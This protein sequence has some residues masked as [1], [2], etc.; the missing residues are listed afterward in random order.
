VHA[1]PEVLP[2]LLLIH[3]I[4]GPTLR[5]AQAQTALATLAA[6]PKVSLVASLDH[7]NSPLRAFA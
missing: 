2:L 1:D 3:N 7:L 5:N 4:D 6:H